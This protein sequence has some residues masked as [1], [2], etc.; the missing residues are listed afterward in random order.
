VD[1]DLAGLEDANRRKKEEIDN[2]NNIPK[3]HGKTEKV[4][5]K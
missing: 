5:R 2:H 1:G 3:G 4:E